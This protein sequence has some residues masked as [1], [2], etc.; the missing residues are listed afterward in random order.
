MDTLSSLFVRQSSAKSLLASASEEVLT[1][2]ASGISDASSMPAASDPAAAICGSDYDFLYLQFDPAEIPGAET[3]QLTFRCDGTAF[4]GASVSCQIENGTLL[5]PLGMNADWLLSENS[6]LCLTFL[7]ADGSK[8]LSTP[9][10]D[11]ADTL[12]KT[13]EFLKLRQ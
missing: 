12:L 11:A 7:G 2:D 1:S 9:L 4:P 3:L 10:E 5:I 8:L 6:D 13:C